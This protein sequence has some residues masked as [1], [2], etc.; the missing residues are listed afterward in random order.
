VHTIQ[1]WLSSVPP[2]VM[3]LLLALVVMVEYMGVP[4]PGEIALVSAALLASS[5]YAQ[6]GWVCVAASVG[7]VAGGSI[8]YYIGHR[9]GRPLLAR[10]GRRFPKHL[11]PRQLAR[12]EGM[13]HR[14]GSAAIFFGRFIALLRVLSGLMAGA[15]R[16]P[17]RRFLVA[18]VTGGVVWAS[19]TALVV[20]SVGNAAEQWLSDFGWVALI[21]AVAAGIVT[22]MIVRRR[23][24]HAIAGDDPI[25][26]D[27]EA[28]ATAAAANPVSDPTSDNA[29][30]PEMASP[31]DATPSE[32][33]ARDA[34]AQG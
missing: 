26:E 6:I 9:G 5:G 30:P 15:L 29:T 25:D 19:G 27:G 22:T 3:Y 32:R 10:L 31:P 24:A 13:L 20:F 7:A 28:V 14:W 17:Q 16:M 1:D 23:A 8:G 4:L 34:D 11:G 12:A 18:N 21:V 2:G 33:V